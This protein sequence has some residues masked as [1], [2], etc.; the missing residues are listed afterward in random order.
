MR[1]ILARA[2]GTLRIFD[3]SASIVFVHDS[4]LGASAG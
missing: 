4:A 2:S 3:S 1:S